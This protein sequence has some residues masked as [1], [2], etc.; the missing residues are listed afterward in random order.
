MRPKV[1][2][3]QVANVHT[4]SSSGHEKARFADHVH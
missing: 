3:D 4:N 1:M 2:V